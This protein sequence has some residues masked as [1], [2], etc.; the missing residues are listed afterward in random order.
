M[1]R[2]A[3]L[4]LALFFPGSVFAQDENLPAI[5]VVPATIEHITSHVLASGFVA[6][7]E[8]VAV[9]PLITGQPI[10]SLEADVG[11]TVVQGQ[12][13]A[14]LSTSTL[15]LEKSRLTAQLAS[16]IASVAQAQAGQAEAAATQ[17]EA[18]ANAERAG[19]LQAQRATSQAAVDQARAAAASADARLQSARQSVAAAEAQRKVAEAQIDDINLQIRRAEVTAPVSGDV[20]ARNA[21]RGSIAASGGEPM[22]ELIR[23]GALELRADVAEEDLLSLARGQSAIMQT[24]T[25]VPLLGL[26]RLV[27]PGIDETTRLG[28]V[29]IRVEDPSRLR[30]GMFAEA[31][32]LVAER[33]TLVLPDTAVGRDADGPFVLRVI[34]GV[35]HRTDVETGIRNAGL[36]EIFTGLGEGD[37]VVAK[38]GAFVREGDRVNPVRIPSE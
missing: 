3:C 25:G 29:R 34:D 26:V 7:V 35:V 19:Q 1:L 5:T 32:I 4:C 10:D 9:Q 27:E 21:V 38:A 8:R 15:E 20:V 18:Q 17:T 33:D 22:F 2:R 11:D 6:P 30:T 14:R 24:V 28:R 23:D 13:L 37:E 12:V 16:A 36:I 31:D